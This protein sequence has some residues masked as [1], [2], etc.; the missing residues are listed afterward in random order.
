MKFINTIQN[1]WTRVALSAITLTTVSSYSTNHCHKADTEAAIAFIKIVGSMIIGQDQ[2]MT[3]FFSLDN[4]TRYSDFIPAF[5]KKETEY[6]HKAQSVTLVGKL[7]KLAHDIFEEA[8]KY[9][10]AAIGVIKQYNGKP[11]DQAL[12]FVADMDKVFSAER[13]F[14]SI[15]TKL[16]LLLTEAEESNE[17]ELVQ[18]IQHLLAVLQKKKTEWSKKTNMSLLT[19]LTKRMSK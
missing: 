12:K 7:S 10:S 13:A 11:A 6:T 14:N 5:T 19:G 9:F 1:N 15:T 2:L 3:Q 17:T 18:V 16:Q 8:R 4:P